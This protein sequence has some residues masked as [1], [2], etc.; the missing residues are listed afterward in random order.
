MTC[1]TRRLS[2]RRK[3]Y[4]S[5]GQIRLFVSMSSRDRPTVA[6]CDQNFVRQ[7]FWASRQAVVARRFTAVHV[8][9]YCHSFPAE[10][11]RGRLHML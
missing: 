3:R 6:H 10:C 1:T 5:I 9:R 4:F 2:F 11:L 8:T 7:C